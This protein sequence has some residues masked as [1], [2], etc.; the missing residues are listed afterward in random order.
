MKAV[1][2]LISIASMFIYVAAYIKALEDLWVNEFPDIG[3]RPDILG[4]LYNL[5]HEK[6]PHNDPQANWFGEETDYFYD[7]MDE[8]LS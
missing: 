1:N 8:M 7:L 2:S 6:T 3:N 4:S 5:G